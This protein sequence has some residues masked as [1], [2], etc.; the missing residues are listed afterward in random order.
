VSYDLY[1]KPRAGSFESRRFSEYFSQRT[2]Y[3]VNGA[4]AWYANED[5]GVYFVFELQDEAEH[6]EGEYFPVALNLN[7]FRPSFFGLEAEPEIKA[8]VDAF[9]M[10]VSDPQ[11]HGMSDGE[12]SSELFLSGWNHGNEFGYAA[13]LRDP[14]SRD[15]LVSLPAADL[16]AAWSWNFARNDLQR[17]LGESKF[18]PCIMFMLIDG[19]PAT[20]AVWPDGIPIAV[21]RVDYFIIPRKRL[22]PRR[23]LRRKEDQALVA[24]EQVLPIFREFSVTWAD[25]TLVL[26]YLNAP[27][28]IKAFVEGLRS[29]E[30]KITGVPADKVLN[31]ELVAKHVV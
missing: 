11:T 13:F 12:Y 2:H 30:S 31:R 24:R 29:N 18:V 15:D 28:E 4:Q 7:F 5:T 21:P 23:F 10:T 17:V 8:F 16:I 26:N 22:A 1:F 9:D 6:A 14:A 20:V 19:Q 27:R 25:G 3:K